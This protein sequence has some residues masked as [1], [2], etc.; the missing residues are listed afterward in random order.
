MIKKIQKI[1]R[2]SVV[3]SKH[4]GEGEPKSTLHTMFDLTRWALMNRGYIPNFFL[5]GLNHKDKKVSDYLTFRSFKNYYREFYP[6]NYLCL[7]EDK[8]VFEKFINN[9]PEYAPKN[10]GFV[11]KYHFYLPDALPQPIENILKHPMRCIVKNTWGFGGRDIFLLTVDSGE[12]YIN[13]VKSTLE[14]FIHKLPER[15]VLQEL[16]EQHE[17]LKALHPSSINTARIVTVNTG[18]EVHTIS[19]FLR[20][21]MGGKFVDNIAQG[22]IYIPIDKK[23]GKLTK[24]G[25]STTEPLIFLSHPQTKVVFN[26]LEIPHFQEAIELCK[27]LHY[28]LSYFFILGWDI[29]FTPTGLT[30]IECN[31]IHKIVDEQRWEGGLKNQMDAYLKEFLENKYKERK[32]NYA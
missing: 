4:N 1:I 12:L 29:A 26:G 3:L 17:V 31:N 22:N 23:T 32:L 14:D 21:G 6:P 2:H 15:A 18:T 5:L 28:Q 24:F 13:G 25:H 7:L 30:V 8:L 19:T 27:K 10:L 11:T 20:I 16:L 9:Y